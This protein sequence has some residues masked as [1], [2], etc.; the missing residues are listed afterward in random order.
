MELPAGFKQL[1]WFGRASNSYADR[2]EGYPVKHYSSTVLEQYVPYIFPQEHGNIEDLRWISLE[3]KESGSTVKVKTTDKLLSGS[4]S[5]FS[6]QQLYD[7]AHTYELTEDN[8]IYLYIDMLHRGLGSASCGP[9][10][11]DKYKI[12]PGEYKYSYKIIVD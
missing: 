5:H 3:D 4:A 9:D 8:K 7:A 1:E 11:L 6:D 10:A 2:K 12:F